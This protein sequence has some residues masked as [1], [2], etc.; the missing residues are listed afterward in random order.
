MTVCTTNLTR[1]GVSLLVAV[2]LTASI[3]FADIPPNDGDPMVRIAYVIPSNRTPQPNGV[4]NIQHTM[5][6]VHDWYGEQMWRWGYG[7]KSFRYETEDDG[8]TPRVYVIHV[9]ETDEYLRE[10]L[11][12]RAREA[13]YAAGATSIYDDGEVWVF[14]PET[15]VQLPTGEIIGGACWGGG[16][17]L[18]IPGSPGDRNG[19]AMVG[20]DALPLYAPGAIHDDTP[21][22]G[23]IIPEIGPYPLVQDVTWAWFL[24]TTISSVSSSYTGAVAH[25]LGHGLGLAHDWRNDGNFRGNLMFNGLRGIRG[26]L[27]PDD[28]PD[29]FTRL[30]YAAGLFQNYNPYFTTFDRGTPPPR[31]DRDDEWP[32]VTILTTGDV[33]P[34]DGHLRITFEAS[35]NVGLVAARLRMNYDTIDEMELSGTEVR[36][37]FVTPYREMSGYNPGDPHEFQLT[38]YDAAGNTWTDVAVITP[39]TGFNYAP[40]PFVRTYPRSWAVVGETVELDASGTSDVNDAVGSLVVEWDLDGDGVFDT[41]P[42]TNKYFYTTFDSVGV[43]VIRLRVTDPHGAVTVSTPVNLRTIPACFGDLDGDGEIGVSDLAR[44]LASYGTASG[45]TYEMGDL[46]GDGD[47]DLSDLAALLSVYGT[48][49]E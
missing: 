33:D 46:D 49:C 8:V 25:E 23:L 37:T 43:P 24:G 39:G 10:A 9:A 42:T 44:L 2:V 30:R 16:G 14:F 7:Y 34:V 6:I 18:A 40:R 21:Y 19:W 35:D 45:A 48:D 31:D 47:V 5:R 28:Y 29:D 22:D 3:A 11:W 17:A 15:H 27:Y 12:D 36:A 26:W 38:V 41:P 1:G 4:A 13:A 20:T 32:T